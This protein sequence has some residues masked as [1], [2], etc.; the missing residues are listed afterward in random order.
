MKVR[1]A[2][3]RRFVCGLP[4]G[5]THGGRVAKLRS[6]SVYTFILERTHFCNVKK[7][8]SRLECLP[9]YTNKIYGPTHFTIYMSDTMIDSA[10]KNIYKPFPKT[11][12]N[13]KDIL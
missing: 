5:S 9:R 12:Q 7:Q 10:D 13:L 1:H 2:I 4:A 11:F 6:I 8:H 3:V